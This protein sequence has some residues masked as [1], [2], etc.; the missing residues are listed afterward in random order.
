MSRWL[1]RNAQLLGQ[2][3]TLD[4]LI[5]NDRIGAIGHQLEVSGDSLERQIQANGA[6]LLPGLVDPLVR[7]REP[8][9]SHKAT[10]AS[11]ARAALA[12]GSTWVGMAADTSPPIDSTAVVEMITR[13]SAAAQ[14]ARVLP[15]AALCRP[16]G[17]SELASLSGAGCPLATD[18]GQ[19]ID[20][21]SLLRRA[22]QY[23]SSLDL[24]VM[25]QPIDAALSGDGVAHDGEIAVRMG[26]SGIPVSAETVALARI[27]LLAEEAQARVIVGPLSSAAAVAQ[28]SQAQARG[29]QVTGLVSTLQLSLNELDLYP[30][31]RDLHLQPPLR[32]ESDRLALIEGLRS[33]VIGLLCS[34][35]QPHDADAKLAPFGE[36]QPGASMLDAHLGL[37]LR[38]VLAGEL[39]LTQW[40]ERA[41]LTA[42]RW[43]G[44]PQ[45]TW[46]AGAEADLIL[47]DPNFEM[48]LDSARLRSA[49]HNSP[50]LKRHLPGRVLAAAIGTHT[51][52]AESEQ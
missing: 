48:P 19:P 8:G 20:D 10:I 7:L 9:A 17:L 26:L 29:V 3:E 33:G 16:S 43:L 34:D 1:I 31:V 50:F 13:R 45:A 23:A 24:P 21:A 37:G 14:G 39:S 22:L 40:V 41:S 42:R 6:W 52:V 4:L 28:L 15:Y 51:F 5:D 11:E 27:L 47:L 35:H 18:Q 32:A 38:M 12:M 2:G 46:E 49:G 25:L 44:L 36:S 30:F